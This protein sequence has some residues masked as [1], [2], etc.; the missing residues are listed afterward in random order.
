MQSLLRKMQRRL[1]R[2]QRMPSQQRKMPR[3]P[4]QL[5]RM[6]S[7]PIKIKRMRV[8]QLRRVHLR[9]PIPKMLKS[10]SLL[11]SRRMLRLQHLHLNLQQIQF[12]LPLLL[13]LHQLQIPFLPQLQLLSLL[14]SLWLSH[15]QIQSQHLLQLLYLRPHQLQILFQLQ[16]LNPYPYLHQHLSLRKMSLPQQPN[17]FPH[18]NLLL[19]QHLRQQLSRRKMSQ[20]LHQSPFLGQ[21]LS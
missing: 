14:P 11:L 15:L 5:K 19:P 6:L 3:M 16:L 7:L 18:L 17:L 1:Q 2:T 10:Q 20:P 21:S 12:R 4:N 9:S 13:Y 8:S